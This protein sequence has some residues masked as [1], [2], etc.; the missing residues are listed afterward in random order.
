MGFVLDFG[1]E[2]FEADADTDKTLSSALDMSPSEA[3]LLVDKF[4]ESECVLVGSDVFREDD[5]TP[6]RPADIQRL[7]PGSEGLVN[8]TATLT[9]LLEMACQ[10]YV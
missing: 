1:L 7:K 3:M 5:Q 6:R 9:E 8:V 4:T 2:L 10:H